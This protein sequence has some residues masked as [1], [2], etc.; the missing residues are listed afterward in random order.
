MVFIYTLLLENGKYY[1][2]KTNNSNFDSTIFN[3]T[4]YSGYSKSDIIK[5]QKILKDLKL[6]N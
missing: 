1:V 5:V 4:V 2:G 6:Y 3:R